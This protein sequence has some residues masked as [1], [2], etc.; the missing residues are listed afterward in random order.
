MGLFDIFKNKKVTILHYLF[1]GLGFGLSIAGLYLDFNM[2]LAPVWIVIV[3]L[4]IF[5]V[6]KKTSRIWWLEIVLS[7]GLIISLL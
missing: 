4:I 2:I 6:T 3:G 5:I 7:F 1:A